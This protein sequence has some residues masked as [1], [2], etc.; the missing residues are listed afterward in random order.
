ML[1]SENVSPQLAFTCSNLTLETL[2]EGVQY[3]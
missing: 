2:G 1:K 3:V